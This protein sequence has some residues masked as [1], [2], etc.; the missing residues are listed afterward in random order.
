MAN[1][2]RSAKSG[3]DWT[4]NEL[5]A[6]HIECHREEPLAFFGVQALPQPLV[7]PELLTSLDA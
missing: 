3:S 6:Y 1:L 7:D 2:I 5:A 4:R